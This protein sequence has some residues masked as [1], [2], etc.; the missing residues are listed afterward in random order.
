MN[1]SDYGEMN[2][3]RPSVKPTPE[4]YQL[5]RRH[6]LRECPDLLEMLFGGVS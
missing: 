2:A 6:V 4:Q 1:V 3:P 5:A